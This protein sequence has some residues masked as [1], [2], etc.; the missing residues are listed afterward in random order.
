MRRSIQHEWKQSAQANL[1]P[2]WRRY[3]TNIDTSLVVVVLVVLSGLEVSNAAAA[4]HSASLAENCDCNQFYEND[5]N[6]NDKQ[7]NMLN[8]VYYY[9]TTLLGQLFSNLINALWYCSKYIQ[10]YSDSLTWKK[11]HNAISAAYSSRMRDKT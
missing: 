1:F 10:I 7:T 9:N 2:G 6:I 8:E 5:I 11:L 3:S 4:A